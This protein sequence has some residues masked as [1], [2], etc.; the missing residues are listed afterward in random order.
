MKS[1][2]FHSLFVAAIVFPLATPLLHAK[3]V[4]F[5]AD[6]PAFAFTMPDSW[7]TETGKDSRRKFR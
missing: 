3:K 1:K 7:S 6:D 2:L 5:P 4:E